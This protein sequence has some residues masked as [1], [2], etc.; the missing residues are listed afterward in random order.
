MTMRLRYEPSDPYVVRA[1]FTVLD[2]DEAVEWIIGRDL[3][4]DGL[5]GPVGEGDI[6]V[7]PVID[8]DP[9]DVYILLSPPAGTALLR[10]SGRDVRAFLY[11]TEELV[12]RGAETGHVDLDASLAQLLGGG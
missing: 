12:P 9:R 5:K 11:E 6:Q 1:A 7:R 4:A 2:S 3:L 10:V 8:H